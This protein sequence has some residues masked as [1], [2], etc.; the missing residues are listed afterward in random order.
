MNWDTAPLLLILVVSVIGSNNTVAIAAALLLLLKLVG[1]EAGFPFLENQGMTIGITILTIAI[2]TPLARGGISLG[3][4]ATV[5][6]NPIGVTALL[7]G[8]LVSWIAG[9]GVFFMKGSPEAVTALVIG[10]IIGVCFFQGLAV[11]P[12][13]AGGLV[14][15]V[16]SLLGRF[17][18]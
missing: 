13:I 3:S 6:K 5:L 7:I 17:T 12:L 14:S 15:L 1:F 9:Q 8:I 18:H 4:M 10:T 16:V 11:G 2:L